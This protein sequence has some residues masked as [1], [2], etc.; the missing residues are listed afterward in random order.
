VYTPTSNIWSLPLP[1][2]A[3]PSASGATAV[4]TGDQVIE[5][6][7]VSLDGSWLLYDSNLAGNSDIYRL[8]VAG[9]EPERLTSDPADDF[10]AA[11]SPDGTE[12]AFHSWRTGSRD[13]WVQPLDGRP[14]QHVTTSP[15]HEWTPEWSPDGRALLYI[16]GVDTRSVWIVRRGPDG[17]WHAPV[18]R[19]ASGYWPV[20][21]PDGQSIAFASRLLGGS[22][23][24]APA[25]SGAS[26]TVL[27]AARP[28][29]PQVE[30]PQW[31]ADGR[32]IYFKSHD[33]RG[34][35]SFWSVP[36]DGGTP[37]LLVPLD[38]PARP[39]Y[40]PQWAL[41][42]DRLFFPIEDRQSDVWVMDVT[43]R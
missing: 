31:S 30:R 29:L 11:I 36:A 12:I 24:V 25:D 35:A 13:L 1:T 8:P 9:G 42:R 19:I 5:N 4:T 15:G 20:W 2:G 7:N 43:P 39:S 40:R 3:S 37:R 34:R 28:G 22:L 23:L 14:I 32:T 33:T 26:R 27:D 17:A 10:A 21:S 38:D 6:L 41:G 18:Q 16:S